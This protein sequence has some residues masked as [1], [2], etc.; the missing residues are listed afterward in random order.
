MIPSAEFY[1]ALHFF[2]SDK[3]DLNMFRKTMF[4]ILSVSLLLEI[5]GCNKLTTENYDQLKIGMNYD[6]VISL[7]GK[8]DECDGVIGIKNCTWG[9]EEKYIKVS[10]AGDKVL[11]FSGHG[12]QRGWTK[13][14]KYKENAFPHTTSCVWYFHITV[15][16]ALHVR[17]VYNRPVSISADT[18]IQL[19]AIPSHGKLCSVYLNPRIAHAAICT[20][21]VGLLWKSQ[22][23]TGSRFLD[24]F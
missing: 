15:V 22:G 6:E 8:A 24:Y 13:K 4:W 9:N 11:V 5:F 23:L 10:F 14:V 2:Y 18:S 7:L 21:S 3:R 17:D 20:G 19:I 16:A 1:P 12:L